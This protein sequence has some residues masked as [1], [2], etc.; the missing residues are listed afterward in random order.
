MYVYVLYSV[1]CVVCI[2]AH[3]EW[4]LKATL[5]RWKKLFDN[6]NKQKASR[7]SIHSS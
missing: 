7:N 1:Y 2:L 3:G 4:I 6:L 5:K